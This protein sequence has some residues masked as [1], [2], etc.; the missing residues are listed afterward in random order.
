MNDGDFDF[1]SCK[2][3]A[4]MGGAFDPIHYGHLV[5]AQ[6]VYDNFNLDRVVIM[7]LGDAPHKEMKG[8]SAYHRFEMARLAAADNDAFG[9]SAME[10]N[11]GGKTYTVDTIAEIKAINPGLEIYFVMGADEILSIESW[12]EPERL[13]KMCAF[14]A[15]TR[16]GFDKSRVEEKTKTIREKYGCEIYFLE[17]PALDISS[18]DIRE[19]IKKGKSA[20]YLTGDETLKYIEKNCLYKEGN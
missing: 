2:R 8:A 9:V 10:V 11:R 7:P 1:K 6:T 13:L 14:I 16:P 12:R 3:I 18:S 5:T 20:R 4:L 17:V 15:V 19:R